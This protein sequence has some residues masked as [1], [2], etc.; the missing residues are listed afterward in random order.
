MVVTLEEFQQEGFVVEP[1]KMGVTVADFQPKFRDKA[2]ES[3]ELKFLPHCGK[4][5]YQ[6][7]SMDTCEDYITMLWCNGAD[8]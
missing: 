2:T 3:T 4:K 6:G 8:L 7:K 5:S 1:Q